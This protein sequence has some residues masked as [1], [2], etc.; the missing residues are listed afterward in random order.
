MI[1]RTAIA[2]P[3]LVVL[4][5]VSVNGCGSGDLWGGSL[6]STTKAPPPVSSPS[7][8]ATV[9]PDIKVEPRVP[10]PATVFKHSIEVIDSIIKDGKPHAIVIALDD[11]LKARVREKQGLV[12]GKNGKGIVI[13]ND[14]N[15]AER[16]LAQVLGSYTFE[17]IEPSYAAKGKTEEQLNLDEQKAEALSGGENVINQGSVANLY[18]DAYTPEKVKALLLALQQLPFVNVAQLI[19][20]ADAEQAY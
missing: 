13:G 16:A 8:E 5:A 15:G 12:L 11:S 2:N 10:R 20:S 19:D 14:Q 3:T 17:A 1:H 9:V 18:L 7:G 4:L 6:Y